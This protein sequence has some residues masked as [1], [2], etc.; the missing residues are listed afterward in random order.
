MKHNINNLAFN[1]GPRACL[2]VAVWVP[3]D[4]YAQPTTLDDRMLSRIT[5][6]SSDRPSMPAQETRSPGQKRQPLAV[7]QL[8]GMDDDPFSG[9]VVSDASAQAE[10]RSEVRL[11]D[12]SQA[13]TQAAN[14]LNTSAAD[15]AGGIN[16]FGQRAVHTGN[17]ALVIAQDNRI[18][19]TKTSLGELGYF[20][21][22][23]S[24]TRYDI[25]RAGGETYLSADTHRVESNDL[26]FS[27]TST[28]TRFDATVL[29][30]AP[31]LFD[32]LS[33]GN[34]K[35]ALP[36]FTL[37]FKDIEV[38]VK[39]PLDLFDVATITIS[40]PRLNVSG[41]FINTG[42]VD[43][44]DDKISL[45]APTLT[46]PELTFSACFLLAG[47]KSD[48]RVTL[49]IPTI[50][51]NL[52]NELTLDNPI[53]AHGIGF[54]YAIAGDGSI[55]VEGGS[56]DLSG[57]IPLGLG[58]ISDLIVDVS[59][60]IIDVI[61]DLG[62]QDDLQLPDFSIPI[63]FSIPLDVP[64]GFN[65][66]FAGEA[67]VFSDG[68]QS[69]KPLDVTTTEVEFSNG[70]Q[71]ETERSEQ[72]Y[73]ENHYSEEFYEHNGEVT[74]RDALANVIVLRNSSA[75]ADEYSVVIVTDSAQAD[76]RVLNV[77]NAANGIVGN[78]LNVMETLAGA[79][80]V[81]GQPGRNL[82]QINT[83]TQIGGR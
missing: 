29:A 72:I 35:I 70:T 59:I 47:C 81:P 77:V 36:S 71:S 15:V 26:H 11:E 43:F 60:P 32:G 83:I 20:T 21:A 48:E 55:M 44:A 52:G 40:P 66:K 58:P 46:L 18:T 69:C 33:I 7:E 6:V 2:L 12:N 4:V 53:S 23:G 27:S 49:T 39:D 82:S 1:L 37:G 42:G 54:G 74:V 65:R 68:Q 10:F 24:V 50:T 17:A 73:S 9:L 22:L 61:L 63:D 62:L 5:A 56:V 79:Q 31:K 34:Q 16:V 45:T 13:S 38:T 78:S 3:F 30:P 14:L 8:P 41:A 51:L 76:I 80:S 64:D 19:Q 57:S 75:E 28:T 25:Q 67:C